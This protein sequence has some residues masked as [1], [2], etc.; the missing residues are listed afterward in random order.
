MHY[1]RIPREYWH[2]RLKMAR[3]MV[4]NMPETME[5]LGQSYGYILNGMP[6]CGTCKLQRTRTTQRH[7]MSQMTLRGYLLDATFNRRTSA[8]RGKLFYRL[9][10]QEV[11]VYPAPLTSLVKPQP[12]A[13]GGVK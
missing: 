5:M 11:Q 6:H 4:L 7:R 3:A 2:D 8:S 13:F 1:A 12:I 9:A 10:Q